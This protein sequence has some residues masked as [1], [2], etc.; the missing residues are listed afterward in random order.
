MSDTLYHECGIALVRLLKPLDY[1]LEKYGT[2][3]YGVNKLSLLMEKQ[4]NRGQDGAGVA[5]I[6]LDMAPGEKYISRYRSVEKNAI[7]HIFGHI[8]GPFREIQKEQPEKL[9]DVAWLKKNAEFMGELLLGHLRYG[10][11]G[12]NNIES[13]HPFLRQN[14]W[15]TRNLVVAGNFNLT[16][17]EELFNNLVD[18]GQ[19]PREKADTVTVMENIGHWLDE[20][21][22]LLYYQYKQEGYT[23]KEISPIIAAKLDIGNILRRSSRYWDG[24]YVMAGLIGHGDAFVLRDPSGIRPAWY[25]ADD[26][27][28]VV[29]SERPQIQ[30]AFNVPA[31]DIR[32]VKPGHALII[33]KNG[34]V[35]EEQIREPLERKSCSFERIYFSRGSDMDIYRERQQLGRNLC[36]AIL[37]SVSRD[38]KHTVFS[39]IPNTAEVAFY[40]MIKGMD[41]FLGEVKKQKILALG[42]DLDDQKL[43]DILAI[44]TRAEKIAIKDAKLRTFI[45]NDIDRSDMVAHVYDIT[46]GTVKAGVDN[47][48][49]IDDSI[50]RGT[51][52]RNS[53]IRMLDRLNPKKIVIVSSAPQIRYPDCYGIDMA[54]IGD[55]IAFRAAISLLEERNMEAL[56]DQ[57]FEECREQLNR[58]NDA[59]NVVKKIYAPFTATEI[60]ARVAKLVTPDDC[61][62][63]VEVIFQKI[64]DLHQAC[65]NH[66]G[67]WYFS[68]N[69][70]TPGGNRVSCRAF[71][72]Y[73]SGLNERAY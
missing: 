14:N 42:G 69:Y 29:T 13:C 19:H 25:Y 54:R 52:L 35:Y 64:E 30:T 40:G 43:S 3:L 72:N 47:L 55:L 2:S 67:D 56:I 20:E 62:A 10:T 23:K 4:H 36:P 46:Y 48:V 37:D 41:D 57:V 61:Q 71:I 28:V 45:T 31:G 6:K 12:G 39:Y 63:E 8:N 5:C 51:T 26:E 1:Y 27:V 33:K 18:I 9:K 38:L 58:G 66:T 22:D 50:V 49:V 34:Q 7:A 60:S 44:R 59:E 68:G 65:P 21:N 32:E 11:F 70:P 15:M 73:V 16:N 17:V 53:I 24:G